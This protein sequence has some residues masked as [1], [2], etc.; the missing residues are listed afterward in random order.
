MSR[1]FTSGGT[2]R[3]KASS[4]ATRGGFLKWLAGAAEEIAAPLTEGIAARKE[5]VTRVKAKPRYYDFENMTSDRSPVHP[6]RMVA[7]ARRIMPRETIALVD[8]GAHRAFAAHYWDSYGPRQF[9]T[10][11]TLGPMGWAIGAGVG[12]K[13]ARPDAPVLV[14]TGDG[15][16]RMHGL[17]V[18]SA[19]RAGLP[20][21]YLVSNNQALGNVWLRARKE[22][23]IPARLTEA[24]DQDWA[25]FARA[26]GAD[27]ATV[28]TPA[29]LQPAL[30]R[31]LASNRTV[32]IDV[33][34]ERAAPTPIEPYAEAQA[35][36][37]FHM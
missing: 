4:A 6:A 5:W 36:W 30:E 28:R 14:F 8:S 10:A 33:K 34:T 24:P 18:Q 26:L 3:T 17:E 16:M 21:I 35:H 9:L 11:A 31:A 15:C 7:D 23:E 12:A 13:A 37:S 32:V 29:E 19:S 25:S 27:G 20:V 1:R 22:G 2:S